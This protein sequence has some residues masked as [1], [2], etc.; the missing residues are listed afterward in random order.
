MSY[1]CQDSTL[2]HAKIYSLAV[3]ASPT[4][5]V[6]IGLECCCVEETLR[7]NLQTVGIATKMAG[8]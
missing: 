6:G 8:Q 2:A 3:D 1:I 7:V 4:T 5:Q